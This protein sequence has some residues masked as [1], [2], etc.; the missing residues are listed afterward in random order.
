MKVIP[1]QDGATKLCHAK[2]GDAVRLI[3][4]DGNRS[5]EV[6]LVAFMEK[7]GCLAARDCASNGLYS[8]DRPLFVVNIETGESKSMPHLS[9][10][11]IILRGAAVV[12]NAID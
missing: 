7:K 4:K 6:Y 8:D 3:D 1:A 2:P 11:V 12:E 9:S 10:R 5:T